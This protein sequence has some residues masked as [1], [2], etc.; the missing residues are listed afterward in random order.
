MNKTNTFIF[1]TIIL[2]LLWSCRAVKESDD[3]YFKPFEALEKDVAKAAHCD[4]LLSKINKKHL[5]S[6]TKQFST[7]GIISP[8]RDLKKE[9]IF[10][11]YNLFFEGDNE[12]RYLGE[13][14]VFVEEK[15]ADWQ[16]FS[17]TETILSITLKDAVFEINPY[18]RVGE[19]LEKVSKFLSPIHKLSDKIYQYQSDCE[20]LILEVNADNIIMN[21]KLEIK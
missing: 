6:L 5:E 21:L 2:S 17:D 4:S 14:F 8:I 18:L 9:G 16:K 13:L 12:V 19:K 7:S 1:L 10:G 20:R 15:P 3:Q 11:H